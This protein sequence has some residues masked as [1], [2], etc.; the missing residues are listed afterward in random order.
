M[1]AEYMNPSPGDSKLLVRKEIMHGYV[2][3][4]RYTKHNYYIHAQELKLICLC[5]FVCLFF[6]FTGP[7]L[8]PGQLLVAR[9]LFKMKAEKI[10]ATTV[11]MYMR[12]FP[13]SLK[14]DFCLFCKMELARK[15]L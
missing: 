2:N 9:T 13:T 4:C 11:L 5:T 14:F 12:I 6:A 1:L 10:N 3:F 7:L 15:K 8:V